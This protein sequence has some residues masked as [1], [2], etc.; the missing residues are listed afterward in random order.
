MLLLLQGPRGCRCLLLLLLLLLLLA[1]LL[2]AVGV[3]VVGEG[4]GARW[5][6][7]RQPMAAAVQVE[8]RGWS[9][10]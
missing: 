2:A 9:G 8:R 6:Q 10:C 5:G 4:E 3:V 7:R 1:A